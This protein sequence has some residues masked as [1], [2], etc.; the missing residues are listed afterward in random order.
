M[1]PETGTVQK[2][3]MEKLEKLLQ[4][5]TCCKLQAAVIIQAC[6]DAI[7]RLTGPVERHRM[8]VKARSVKNVQEDSVSGGI[9]EEILPA[10]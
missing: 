1:N 7:V 2:Y 5:P 8:N 9:S 3:Y 6:S 10:Q 4:L